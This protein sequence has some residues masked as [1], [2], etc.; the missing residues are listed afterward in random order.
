[1]THGLNPY[2]S[3]IWSRSNLTSFGQALE[4]AGLILIVVEYGLGVISKD[5]IV[6]LFAG[7][8]LIVVEYGLGVRNRAIDLKFI[9]K[10]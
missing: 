3:G 9:T 8:I 4:Q 2:C 5:M 10:A 7:L 1:M 6:K